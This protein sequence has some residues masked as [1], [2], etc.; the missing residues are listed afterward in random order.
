MGR[1][2]SQFFIKNRKCLFYCATLLEFTGAAKDLVRRFLAVTTLSDCKKRRIKAVSENRENRTAI[3]II[4]CIVFPFARHNA[5]T[6]N[7]K[8]ATQFLSIEIHTV[9]GA[10]IVC[11]TNWIAQRYVPSLAIM[12]VIGLEN[13]GIQRMH[14]AI[15]LDP[16]CAG[17][18]GVRLVVT[19]D[20]G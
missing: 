10:P 15:L 17:A 7:I 6:I 11:Q 13:D 3:L 20:C 16:L 12:A 2:F 18:V 4:D 9:F 1:N 19:I 5:P 8:Q 14:V